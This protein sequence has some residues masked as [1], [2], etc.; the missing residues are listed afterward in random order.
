MRLQRP[1]IFLGKLDKKEDKKEDLMEKFKPASGTWECS[2]C[3][4]RNIQT[5]NKCIACETLREATKKEEPPKSLGFSSQF[6][7]SSD[8]WECGVCLVRNDSKDSKCVACTNPKPSTNNIPVTS[9]FGDKFKPSNDTWECNVCMIR[10]KAAVSKCVACESLKPGAKSEKSTLIMPPTTNNKS[11]FDDIVKK[12]QERW[13]CST[14]LVRNPNDE[15]K[16]TSCGTY[17]PG[18]PQFNFAIDSTAPKFKFGIDNTTAGAAST[19]FT[20]ET[21]SSTSNANTGFKFGVPTNV[22]TPASS[23]T[24]TGFQFGIP[25]TAAATPAFSFGVKSAEKTEKKVDDKPA[26]LSFGVENERKSKSDVVVI[27]DDDDDD[28]PVKRSKPETKDSETPKKEP[29]KV[30]SSNSFLF[31]AKSNSTDGMFS[32]TSQSTKT[33]ELPKPMFNFGQ[34]KPS[35]VE[36]KKITFDIPEKEEKPAESDKAKAST[37]FNFNATQN[38]SPNTAASQLFSFGSSTST[39]PNTS[40]Q[41]TFASSFQVPKFNF[42]SNSLPFSSKPAEITSTVTT[43][44]TSA[45]FNFGNSS[46]TKSTFE[47]PKQEVKPFSFSAPTQPKTDTFAFKPNDKPSFNFGSAANASPGNVF[48]FEPAKPNETPTFGSSETKPT[49][50]F[51][52]STS[53]TTQ[54]QPLNGG[55]N[56]APAASSSTFKFGSAPGPATTQAPAVFSFGQVRTFIFLN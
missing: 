15:K 12:Q 28:V 23:G 29:A 33:T 48:S 43:T 31:G 52:S 42:G 49:A 17:R 2:T 24:S 51:G 19:G 8:K 4:V 55:F 21:S 40:T 47:P 45:M 22:T 41:A 20:S 5:A 39:T 11:G 32:N 36:E 7:M 53:S 37:L 54:A 14:C 38:T 26:Q 50:L 3:M 13:E 9:G 27:D 25:S 16:C 34:P 56:F 1:I 44:N 6:K 30:S 18:V 46:T 10:N 35:S